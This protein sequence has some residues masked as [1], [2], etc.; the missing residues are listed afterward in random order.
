MGEEPYEQDEYEGDEGDDSEEDPTEEQQGDDEDFISNIIANVNATTGTI[1]PKKPVTELAPTVV[2]EM[3]DVFS[4]FDFNNDGTIAT[5]DLGTV[6]RGLGQ[7][8]TEAQI[9]DF[10]NENDHDGSG[11]L[12]FACFF[13]IVAGNQPMRP[14]STL[15]EVEEYFEPFDLYK[16]GL[17]NAEDFIIMLKEMGEPLTNDD[18]EHLLREIEIDGDNKIDFRAFVRHMFETSAL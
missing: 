3:K 2:A 18:V 8:L 5:E 6:L 7:N 11:S 16:D 4:L 17:M 14:A 1:K 10:I 13:S 9:S 12:D 15:E